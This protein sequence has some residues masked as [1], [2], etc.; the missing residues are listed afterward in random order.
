MG[1]RRFLQRRSRSNPLADWTPEGPVDP[2]VSL[3][4][5]R[6]ML[7]KVRNLEADRTTLLEI[8]QCAQE[9]DDWMTRGGY[10]PRAWW[11][12]RVPPRG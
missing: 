4:H 8:A 12:V 10:M 6:N 1:V 9:L 3:G 11:R 5:M 7:E 2:D